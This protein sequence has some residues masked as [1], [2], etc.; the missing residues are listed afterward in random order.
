MSTGRQT[1][2]VG[3]RRVTA[4]VL[5]SVPTRRGLAESRM[6]VNSAFSRHASGQVLIQT[7]TGYVPLYQ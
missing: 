6:G 3:V 2:D 5:S 7:F 1:I 4:R